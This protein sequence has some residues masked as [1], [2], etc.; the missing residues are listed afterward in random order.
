MD[1]QTVQ[2]MENAKNMSK[3]SKS[4]QHSQSVLQHTKCRLLDQSL[5]SFMLFPKDRKN[6]KLSSCHSLYS[7][8]IPKLIELDDLVVHC[9]EIL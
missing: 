9:G 6:G 3:H 2:N 7:L 5:S 8:L 4:E 1:R